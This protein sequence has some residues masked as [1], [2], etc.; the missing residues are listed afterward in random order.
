MRERE[1]EN[2]IDYNKIKYIMKTK[3]N[4]ICNVCAS[5]FPWFISGIQA[6]FT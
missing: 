2:K 3:R 6:G 5:P 1:R 4:L